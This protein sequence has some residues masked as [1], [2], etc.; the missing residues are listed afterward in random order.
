MSQVRSGIVTITAYGTGFGTT[1]A[2][3]LY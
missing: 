3:R 2:R 1:C